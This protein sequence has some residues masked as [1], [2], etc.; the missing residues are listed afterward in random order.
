MTLKETRQ[1]GIEF[2]RRLQTILPSTK[3]VDKIDTED[4]YAFL[5]QY[6]NQF[7]KELYVSQNSE[8]LSDRAQ[9][10]ISDYLKSLYTHVDIL[11]KEYTYIMRN[12]KCNN[13]AFFNEIQYPGQDFEIVAQLNLAE[14]EDVDTQNILSIGTGIAEWFQDKNNKTYDNIHIFYTPSK[15]IIQFEAVNKNFPANQLRKIIPISAPKYTLIKL[16]SSGLYLNGKLIYKS[17]NEIIK[18]LFDPSVKY[19]Q[20]GSVQGDTRST[21]KYTE[22]YYSTVRDTLDQFKVED[23]NMYISSTSSIYGSYLN[24]Y[25]SGSKNVHNDVDNEFVDIQTF[26]KLKSTVYNEHR[27]LR[28]PVITISGCD[29]KGTLFD[30][31]HDEYTHINNISIYYVKMPSYFTILGDGIACKLPIECFNELVDGAVR[32]YISYKA[33]GATQSQSTS[34]QPQNQSNT[35]NNQQ[36]NG[37]EDEQ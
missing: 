8:Q 27:I 21:A 13:E 9:S 29:E 30:I 16:N 14:C 18:N 10:R 3:T 11:E 12:Y 2:E 33:G 31:I 24:P 25:T 22:I 7:V 5:N 4:I 17:D 32:L 28:N 6:Q 15:K 37:Q 34:K 26:Q 19:I 36:T 23:M 1:L 35:Q 20:V